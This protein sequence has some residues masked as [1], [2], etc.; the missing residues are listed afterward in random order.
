MTNIV[1]A[2]DIPSNIVTLEQLMVWGNKCL[3]QL[4]PAL[5]AT[6]GENYVQRVVQSGEFYIATNNTTRH[7]GR[8]S[9]EMLPEM[10]TGPLKDWMYAKDI[11]T[12]ALTAAMKAN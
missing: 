8:Q 5:N 6:E 11:G 10:H 3:W 12:L 4:Y 1:L 7:I 9:I 2:T